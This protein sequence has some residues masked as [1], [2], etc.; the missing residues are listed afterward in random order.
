MPR[1]KTADVLAEQLKPLWE[2]MKGF[3]ERL[4]KLENSPTTPTQL[5]G[6]KTPAAVEEN[7]LQRQ[8][9]DE[10]LNKHFSF[11]T[12]QEFGG[13]KLVIL[14][15]KK[16]STASQGHWDMYG[17]D[18]RPSKPFASYEAEVMFRMHVESVFNGFNPDIKALIVNDR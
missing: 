7:P 16:Y 3:E 5:E 1:P 4:V 9:V 14:V 17:A 18:E 2:T 15:P 11:R 8:L 12:E 6:V 13:I 10:I